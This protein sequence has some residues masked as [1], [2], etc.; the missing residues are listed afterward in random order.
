MKKITWITSALLFVF[1]IAGCKKDD[2]NAIRYRVTKINKTV[3]TSPAQNQEFSFTYNAAG[4][5]TRVDLVGSSS[6]NSYYFEYYY[7]AQLDSIRKMKTSDGSYNSTVFATWSGG[8]LSAFWTYTFAYDGQ[9]RLDKVTY[10]S[11][12]F[13]RF[14]YAADS[15][16]TYYKPVASAEYHE[17]SLTVSSTVKNPYLIV[18][19]ESEEKTLAFAL[20]GTA[21]N[22]NSISSYLINYA[23]GYNSNGS[24]SYEVDYTPAGDTDAYPN[25]INI[26]SDILPDIVLEFTYEAI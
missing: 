14:A 16:K 13:N 7:S 6:D 5:I 23:R 17:G 12:S 10:G 18:N 3:A 22:Y 8:K 24:L 26:T 1:A 20:N 15:I 9:G 2:P 19:N 25:I 4:K 21:G 11:G